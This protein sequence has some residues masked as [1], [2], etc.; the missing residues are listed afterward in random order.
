VAFPDLTPFNWNDAPSTAT[1]I[2]AANLEDQQTHVYDAL[3]DDVATIIHEAAPSIEYWGASPAATATANTIAINTAL[4]N[5]KKVIVPAGK[6]YD[7]NGTLLGQS[8]GVLQIDGDLVRTGSYGGAGSAAIRFGDGATQGNNGGITGRG[9]VFCKRLVDDAID[10]NCWRNGVFEQ[11]VLMDPREA[12]V[13]VRNTHASADCDSH[14]FLAL[15]LQSDG[16]FT[17]DGTLR[18]KRFI[19]L[20]GTGAALVTDNRIEACVAIGGLYPETSGGAGDGAW[21]AEVIDSPRNRFESN[22]WYS[23][24]ERSVSGGDVGWNGGYLVRSVT[25]DV[26]RTIIIDPYCEATV[27]G[28]PHASWVF[29]LVRFSINAGGAARNMDW[30]QVYGAAMNCN[31]TAAN[32]KSLRLINSH[33]ATSA[34]RY[35][36][37]V[38]PRQQVSDPAQIIV[39]T[40]CLQNRIEV[41]T[42]S[43]VSS[44]TWTNNGGTT[45]R[46]VSRA[47]AALSS[48]GAGG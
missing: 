22:Q 21:G 39:G 16:T 20:D 27:S 1:P 6:S 10:I 30:N 42:D 12:A 32:R 8:E 35:T 23:H 24:V 33:G 43:E 48:N 14:K 38:Q 17:A 13:R 2:T 4:T 36:S 26:G 11:V 31:A 5:S 25:E 47:G 41:N 9:R 28:S 7:F 15:R 34:I 29:E 44:P 37:W 3:V 19:V 46:L 18:P 45:N 40:N